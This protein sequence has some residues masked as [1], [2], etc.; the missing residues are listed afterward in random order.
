MW[1]RLRF[2][3]IWLQT[4]PRSCTNQILIQLSCYGN[5]LGRHSHLIIN[6]FFFISNSTFM[7]LILS[8]LLYSHRSKHKEVVMDKLSRAETGG[9]PSPAQAVVNAAAARGDSGSSSSSS[10][11]VPHSAVPSSSIRARRLRSRR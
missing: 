10:D 3:L 6:I 7:T 1:K 5:N 9:E 2:T 11:S 4:I 8:Y